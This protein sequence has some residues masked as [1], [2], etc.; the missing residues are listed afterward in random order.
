[1]SLFRKVV[2]EIKEKGRISK[3]LKYSIHKAPTMNLDLTYF[4]DF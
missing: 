3:T 2:K 1:M 4:P